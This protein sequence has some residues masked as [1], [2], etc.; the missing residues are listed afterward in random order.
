MKTLKEKDIIAARDRLQELSRVQ[1]EARGEELKIRE[2]L[3]KG[4]YPKDKQE[5]STTITVGATKLTL[6][7]AYRRTISREDAEKLKIDRPDLY[8]TVLRFN[9]EVR[10]GVFKE[11]EE[12]LASYIDT[13]PTPPAV[14]FK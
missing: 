6:T 7:V 8:A 4:L 2:Y 9:P 11:H 1:T 13:K 5:G 3:V 14:A 12:E 10:V